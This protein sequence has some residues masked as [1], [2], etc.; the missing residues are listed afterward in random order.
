MEYK[1][2]VISNEGKNKEAYELVRKVDTSAGFDSDS[3]N[4]IVYNYAVELYNGM[5]FE[6]AYNILEGAT[7]AN[8]VEL[9]KA[10]AYHL[11][12]SLLKEKQYEAAAE[13]FEKAE[14]YSDAAEKVKQCNYQ[15]GIRAYNSKHYNDALGFFK[16]AD[17]Y[18]E[19]KNYIKKIEEKKNEQTFH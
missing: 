9:R 6:E 3:Y 5:M 12:N 7:D 4:I 10:S 13:M 19:S 14:D 16:K 8:S 1:V 11:G 17:G 18:K 2:T 15:L